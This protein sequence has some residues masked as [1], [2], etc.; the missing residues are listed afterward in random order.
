MSLSPSPTSASFNAEAVSKLICISSY[1][2]VQHEG[3][4]RERGQR[5]RAAKRRSMQ[6]AVGG[7][8]LTDKIQG[9]HWLAG[10][11]TEP[12][13]WPGLNFAHFLMEVSWSV[14]V[15]L[16]T[17]WK[18]LRAC[19]HSPSRNVNAALSVFIPLSPH[20]ASM[21]LHKRCTIQFIL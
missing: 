2:F 14:L 17:H 21:T 7:T 20:G 15:I 1:V 9:C 19:E 10:W 16:V 6:G 11:T 8:M 3:G 5:T 4:D 18:S 13:F 12:T